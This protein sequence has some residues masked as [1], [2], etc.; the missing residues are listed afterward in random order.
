M[1]ENFYL[2]ALGE[3]VMGTMGLGKPG[4][5]G[6]EIVRVCEEEKSELLPYQDECESV[7]ESAFVVV[8]VSDLVCGNVCVSDVCVWC[9]WCVC[10]M[11]C[12][13]VI[14]VPVDECFCG[15][16][17]SEGGAVLVCCACCADV[18]VSVECVGAVCAC[19]V[20]GI[21]MCFVA[22]RYVSPGDLGVFVG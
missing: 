20:I 22:E 18:M 17:V 15:V 9:V 5:D 6:N 14:M 3:V 19:E 2:F 21:V 13:S 4:R 10:E 1:I 12:W 16:V 7:F 11:L 8:C